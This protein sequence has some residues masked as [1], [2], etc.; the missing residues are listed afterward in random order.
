[1]AASVDPTR[2]PPATADEMVVES[3]EIVPDETDAAAVAAA[4]GSPEAHASVA[5]GR[6]AATRRRDLSWTRGVFARGGARAEQA[7]SRGVTRSPRDGPAQSAVRDEG[8]R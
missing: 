5:V 4:A 8:V 2:V 7:R 3:E 1:M 6:D